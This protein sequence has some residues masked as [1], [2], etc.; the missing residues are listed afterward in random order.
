MLPATLLQVF[1]SH[2]SSPSLSLSF[3]LSLFAAAAV[4]VVVVVVRF[5]KRRSFVIRCRR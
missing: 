2:Q 1:N 3:W 5:R 4:V